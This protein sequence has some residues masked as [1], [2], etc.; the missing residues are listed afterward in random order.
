[1]PC[2]LLISYFSYLQTKMQKWIILA[3]NIFNLHGCTKP[4]LHLKPLL[5]GCCRLYF[6]EPIAHQSCHATRVRAASCMETSFLCV[7]GKGPSHYTNSEFKVHWV[8]IKRPLQQHFHGHVF[9]PWLHSKR[10][11]T[12]G[13]LQSFNVADRHDTYLIQHHF[14]GAWWHKFSHE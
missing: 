3:H 1:M 2:N 13:G 5:N 10:P 7:N 9:C 4:A 8:W 6:H 12:A 14:S 11:M